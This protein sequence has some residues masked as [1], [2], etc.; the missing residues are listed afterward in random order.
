MNQIPFRCIGREDHGEEFLNVKLRTPSFPDSEIIEKTFRV[1]KL[2][3]RTI[4][5]DKNTQN[6]VLHFI[7]VE[8]FYDVSLPL[9]APFEG[10]V[11]DIAGRILSSNSISE[12]KI[13]LSELKTGNYILK[14]YTDKGIKNTKI[15]KE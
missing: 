10:K 12:N 9:F 8:F 5:R 13:D 14:L 15:L 2:S 4:V 7:S 6:F 11:T 1:F 3:D